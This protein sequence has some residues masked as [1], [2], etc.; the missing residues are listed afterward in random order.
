MT[1]ERLTTAPEDPVTFTITRFLPD[2]FTR[3]DPE[4]ET[5]VITPGFTPMLFTLLRQT[6]FFPS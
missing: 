6:T 5:V 4:N 3:G 1:A 2:R